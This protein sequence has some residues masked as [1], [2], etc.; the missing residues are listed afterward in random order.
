M[1]LL[2]IRNLRSRAGR[3]FFTAFAIALG[4]ALVFATRIV[5]VAADEQAAAARESKL[6]G[7]DLEVAAVRAQYFPVSIADE[8]LKNPAV[9]KVA[10]IYRYALADDSLQLLGIDPARVLTPYELIAG[11]FIAAE[12]EILLPDIWAAQNGLGVGQT[13]RLMI[14]DQTYEFKI[15]GLIKV[16]SFG[17]PSAWVALPTLQAALHRPKAA[18]SILI[19]L[20]QGEIPQVVKA[21]LVNSLGNAYV[22]TS[23][24]DSAVSL[25]SYGLITSLAFPF[26][27]V[28]VLL[29]SAYLIFN[30]FALTLT[31][32]KREIGQLRALGMTRGQ[33]MAQTLT[34]AALV[35]GAGSLAGLP[36]G[37][38]LSVMLVSI[39]LGATDQAFTGQIGF[40][41]VTI[42]LDGV[43]LAVGLG[44]LTTLTSTFVL[45]WQAGRVSPLAALLTEASDK[46]SPAERLYERWGWVIGLGLAILFGV[47]NNAVAAYL[48]EGQTTVSPLVYTFIPLLIPPVIAVFLLPPLMRGGLWLVERV[49]PHVIAVR[50]A[51]GNIRKQ[52]SRA[53]LTAATFTISL[54]LVVAF[55]GMAQGMTVYFSKSFVRV[56]T[57]DFFLATGNTPIPAD[58]EA[59]LTA[60][61]AEAQVFELALTRLPGYD[62]DSGIDVIVADMDYLRTHASLVRPIEGSLDEAERYSASG[63]TLFLTEA[64]ARRRNL[65]VGDTTMVDTLAGPVAFTVGLI[66]TGPTIIPLAYGPRYFGAHPHIFLVT[67]LPGH[68]KTAVGDKLKAIANK[69]DLL[70]V[71][72][73]DTWVFDT[74][75]EQFNILMG[76]FAGLTSISVIIASLN[77]VNLLV[78]SVLERQ[79]ELGTLRALGLTQA[80][81][82]ALI[83]A[84]AGLLG[85]LGSLLGV[86][87]ALVISWASVRLFAAWGQS[88]YGPITEEA[89]TLPWL[90]ASV[91]LILG[92]GIAMLA[93]L[94]PADRATS[95]N[96]ADAMRAE[97]ATGFLPPAKHLGPI[98]VRG[99]VARL[100]LAA[101]LSLTI[102]LVI[103]LTIGALTALR[104]N[105]ERQLLEENMRAI[106]ARAVELMADS[107]ESQLPADVTELTSESLADL[108]QMADT[109]AQA[110]NEFFQGGDSPYDFTLKYLFITDNRHK[111]IL[112][113]RAEYNNTILTNTVSLAGAASTVRL[114]DWTGERAF[115]AV[116]AVKNQANQPVGYVRVGLSTEPVDNIV[117]DIVRGS[118]GM[119]LAAL[120]LASLLTVFFTRRALA[121]LMQIAE[122]SH[123]VARGD[124]S[125]RVPESRWD[126]VGGLARSFNEMVGDLNDRERMRQELSLARE[127][128]HTLL[129]KELPALPG[130]QLSAH[131]QPAREVGGDFYDFIPLPDDRLG[132]VIADVSGKGIPAA[133]VMATAR[134]L[135]RAAALR[136]ASPGAVLEQVNDLLHPDI[137]PKMFVTCLYAILDPANGQLCYANAG[138]DLPY[139]RANGR[140][141]ELRATGMPL[142][143]LPGMR[144]DE[145][146]TVLVPGESVLFYSDG[147]VEAHNPQREMFGFPRLGTL[148]ANHTG[149]AGLIE[150][151]LA[152]LRRFTGAGWEQEDDVTL[153]VLQRLA[154][155]AMPLG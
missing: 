1:L 62:L 138:H 77:L 114:T 23:A 7:A 49:F 61:R 76:L 136:L 148:L 86:V 139:R 68:N 140:V 155:H 36:F 55:A 92:P 81:V 59:R 44:F 20:K 67:A 115:E 146:E 147:L 21:D 8:I 110:V 48:S 13:V 142:G 88:I 154:S 107:V 54:M 130:W 118:V 144:Y 24:Q 143:L 22:V 79:R 123:A 51:V 50:L 137:P 75:N 103:A 66:E 104:V 73:P 125:W 5:G 85:L 97:G 47:T 28:V 71:D 2:A 119:M 150:F 131:Y 12:D 116:V 11:Q 101:K 6:A 42:P 69:Y 35:A 3:T 31:E 153:V 72:D 135:L 32:R 80:Q 87:G 34:E 38:G 133:L 106:F 124:L 65:R 9:E 108:P 126:E 57:A 113:N 40:T 145:K 83:T 109:Q 56:L 120:A 78:A 149:R 127:I 15:V 91:A 64:V 33:V 93:A 14:E 27:S 10:P 58:L 95:V 43:V 29:S 16:T 41:S 53:W 98:G 82:R 121:P 84:E 74:V 60:L 96:P 112:S 117:R 122:A 129:P 102:G 25:Q 89:P 37:L 4:V 39:I 111:V 100:P 52:K 63:P 94:W 70:L 19:R 128:Q 45:A 26:A 30:T 151:L 141:A 105:Y 17:T 134:S 90:V 18:N 99:L 132:L 46:E 152:E